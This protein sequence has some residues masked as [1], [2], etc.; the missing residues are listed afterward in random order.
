MKNKTAIQELIEE[1]ES[2]LDKPY[3]NPQ[4]ALNDC[5]NLAFAKLER[6]KEQQKKSFVQGWES[7]G[8]AWGVYMSFEHY[9]KT[10][11]EK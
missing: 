4:N 2:L 11:F 10:N 7:S 3:I 9:Y 8:E 6:E 1:I 5:I